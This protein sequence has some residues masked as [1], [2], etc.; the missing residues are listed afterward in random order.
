M[1]YY[2]LYLHFDILIGQKKVL[3]KLFLWKSWEIFVDIGCISPKASCYKSNCC[4]SIIFFRHIL[5]ILHSNIIYFIRYTNINLVFKFIYFFLCH[6]FIWVKQHWYF[7]FTR[8]H[9]LFTKFIEIKST[10]TAIEIMFDYDHIYI[11]QR[12]YQLYSIP[13]QKYIHQC[14]FI[15]WKH[16]PPDTL[17]TYNS[18]SLLS[19]SSTWTKLSQSSVTFS[20]LS[21]AKSSICHVHS[22]HSQSWLSAAFYPLWFLAGFLPLSSPCLPF[23]HKFIR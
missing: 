12:F 2:I 6:H 14:Q 21:L 5:E 9:N 19:N 15:L 8:Y 7:F 23:S 11:C 22:G 18:S 4:F 17:F 10:R 3:S 13:C 1:L 20:F 16:C